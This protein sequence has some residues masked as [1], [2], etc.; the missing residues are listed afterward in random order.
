MY[1][2]D[3]NVVSELRKVKSGKADE[4]VEAWSLTVSP[5]QLYLSVI[6]IHEIELGILMAERSD[7]TKGRVL[8]KWMNEYVLPAF[9]GRILSVDQQIALVSAG[10]H[11]PDPKPYRDTLIV[12]TALVHGMTVVTR[13]THDF[14]LTG[15]KKINPWR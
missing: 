2:L 5:K 3:T 9:D 7:F 1:L 10:Y 8:R 13:N 15:V 11:V 12:A 14:C 4:H 6:V